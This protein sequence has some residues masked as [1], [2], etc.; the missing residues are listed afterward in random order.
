MA[1]VA[2]IFVALG[3]LGAA[4]TFFLVGLL[5][6]S[7]EN[8]HVYWVVQGPIWGAGVLALILGA[9]AA[10]LALSTADG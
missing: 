6:E 3:A 5:A 7:G 2:S 10:W 1:K 9:V 8:G 4:V